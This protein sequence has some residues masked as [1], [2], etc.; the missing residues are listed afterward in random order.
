MSKEISRY[1]W[2]FKGAYAIYRGTSKIKPLP[3]EVEITSKIEVEDIDLA[4]NRVKL[5]IHSD[6][7]N[8]VWRLSKKISEEEVIDWVKIGDRVI[9]S[10]TPYTVECE[11]ECVMHFP[12]IGTKR[13]IAQVCSL[14]K[15]MMVIFWDNEL[16]WPLIFVSIFTYR[17]KTPGL[18]EDTVDTIAYMIKTV[19]G[20]H[21]KGLQDTLKRSHNE[22]IRE[23]SLVISLIDTNIPGLKA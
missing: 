23:Y 12:G 8:R 7:T 15:S 16:V 5:R 19:S 22:M 9:P 2:L 17:H 13:C 4:N 21:I 18:L 10:D 3:G 20:L 11:Y 6:A 14:P 1:P